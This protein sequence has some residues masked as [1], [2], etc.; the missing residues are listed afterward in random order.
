[1]CPDID[2]LD[3]FIG[4][5]R[6]LSKY[7]TKVSCHIYTPVSEI[8]SFERMISETCGKRVLTKYL[9]RTFHFRDNIGIEF[10]I[11]LLETFGI[12]YLHIKHQ[13]KQRVNPY[14]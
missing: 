2:K 12:E 1:M 13:E 11:V 7:D 6:E 14:Q 3:E 4:A 8:F 10:S 5:I 9:D